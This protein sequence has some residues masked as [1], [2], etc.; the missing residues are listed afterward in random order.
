V[1]N[2]QPESTMRLFAECLRQLYDVAGL[3]IP[4]QFDPDIESIRLSCALV[5]KGLGIRP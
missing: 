2:H 5:S 4:K 1:N 3:E